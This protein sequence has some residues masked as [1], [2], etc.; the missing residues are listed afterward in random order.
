MMHPAEVFM[1]ALCS[2]LNN[3]GW[4]LVSYE[5]REK[6]LQDARWI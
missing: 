4:T 5:I 3:T 6:I 1:C 2:M